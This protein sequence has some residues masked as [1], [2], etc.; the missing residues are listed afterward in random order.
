VAVTLEQLRNTVTIIILAA[1]GSGDDDDDDDYNDNSIQFISHL[2]MC[3][4][5]STVANYKA[6]KIQ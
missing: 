1:T 5:K 2:L 3:Q 4:T 6:Q